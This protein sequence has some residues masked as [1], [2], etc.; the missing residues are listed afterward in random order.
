L[1]QKSFAYYLSVQNTDKK[2]KRKKKKRSASSR[3]RTCA[4]EC[5][6]F[7]TLKLNYGQLGAT[8]LK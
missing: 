7:F 8:K 5:A 2:A 6:N 4:V 3:I 1:L